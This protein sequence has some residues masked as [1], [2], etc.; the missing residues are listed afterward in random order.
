MSYENIEKAS[1][2]PERAAFLTNF[3]K[4]FLTFYTGEKYGVKVQRHIMEMKL[5]T[6][7]AV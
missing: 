4:W 2:F 3:E 5:P 6:N 1:G 7:T